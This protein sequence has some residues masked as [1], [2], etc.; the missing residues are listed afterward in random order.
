MTTRKYRAIKPKPPFADDGLKCSV[1]VAY[2]DVFENGII[3]P[4]RSRRAQICEVSAPVRLGLTQTLVGTDKEGR[5]TAVLSRRTGHQL[6]YRTS[7]NRDPPKEKH[8]V[9]GG[10]ETTVRECGLNGRDSRRSD[11]LLRCAS[12]LQGASVGTE[13]VTLQGGEAS[14]RKE[15]TGTSGT[16]GEEETTQGKAQVQVAHLLPREVGVPRSKTY[17][18]VQAVYTPQAG[19]VNLG[20]ITDS[21]VALNLFGPYVRELI[22]FLRGEL[23]LPKDIHGQTPLNSEEYIQHC[24]YCGLEPLCIKQ[25][26]HEWPTTDLCL[27]CQ[28]DQRVSVEMVTD[29]L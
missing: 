14:E 11:S 9:I 3:I 5:R 4:G 15:T 17:T 12:D 2:G 27:G 13:G 24:P 23:Y 10:G 7:S 1:C 22:L 21:S 25:Q 28:P 6:P 16:Q 8:R 18:E 29:Q 26:V 19:V 20:N